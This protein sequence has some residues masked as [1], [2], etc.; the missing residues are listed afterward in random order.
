MSCVQGRWSNG[1]FAACV[2]HS[3]VP[4][5]TIIYAGRGTWVFSLWGQG[6]YAAA[7]G[8]TSVGGN[9]T[10]YVIGRGREGDGG[11]APVTSSHCLSQMTF[12]CRA[13]EI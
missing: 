4:N 13:T 3:D 8:S 10:E 7:G 1:S 2:D 5:D 6:A 11:P 12:Q 9:V